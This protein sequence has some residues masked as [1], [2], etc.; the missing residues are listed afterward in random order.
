MA[1]AYLK[2]LP[3]LKAKMIRLKQQTAPAIRP[4]ME[5]AAGAICGTMRSVVPVDQGDLR[6]SIGWTWGDAPK[7][8]FGVSHSIG[9]N[10]ITIFAGNE[11]AFYARWVEFGTAPHNVAPGGGTKGFKKSGSKG[12]EHPGAAARPF[13][14]PSYRMHKKDVKRQ[15]TQALRIAVRDAVK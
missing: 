11:T 6:S 15:I 4:A 5:A 8:S 3:R 14:Y 2:N 9:G 13:F 7:G 1:R 12:V 10:K